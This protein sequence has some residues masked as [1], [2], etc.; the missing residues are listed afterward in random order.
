MSDY[1]APTAPPLP[2]DDAGMCSAAPV[3]PPPAD[4]VLVQLAAMGYPR[5]VCENALRCC[6]GAD[7]Q[8]AVAWLLENEDGTGSSIRGGRAVAQQQAWHAPPAACHADPYAASPN[9]YAPAADAS[10]HAAAPFDEELAFETALNDILLQMLDDA[11]VDKAAGKTENPLKET[12]V[13]APGAPEAGKKSV[14]AGFASKVTFQEVPGREDLWTTDERLHELYALRRGHASVKRYG[15]TD[16]VDTLMETVADSLHSNALINKMESEVKKRGYKV[17]GSLG[18]KLSKASNS[19]T[20]ATSKAGGLFSSSSSSA[21]PA[22]P[23]DA[24]DASSL[25]VAGGDGQSVIEV[26][27]CVIDWRSTTYPEIKEKDFGPTMRQW[28]FTNVPRGHLSG[29][30]MGAT[31]DAV[32]EARVRWDQAN[33]RDPVLFRFKTL[34]LR[35]RQAEHQVA[36]V[37]GVDPNDLK[38]CLNADQAISSVLKSL[39][40]APGDAIVHTTD[41]TASA[42]ACLRRLSTTHGVVLYDATA[43]LP[44]TTEQQHEHYRKFIADLAARGLI[45]AVKLA[46]FP[47]VG[48]R[49]GVKVSVRK[50]SAMF[51]KHKVSVLV[52][53]SMAVGNVEV[54]LSG[55]GADWYVASLCHWMFADA[56][57]GVI[58]A[59]P[60]KQPVTE[61]LTVSYFDRGL[62]NAQKHNLSFEKEFSYQGLQDFAGWCAVHQSMTFVTKICGGWPVVWRHNQALAKRVAGEVSAAWGTQPVQADGQYGSMPVVPLPNAAGPWCTEAHAAHLT[63]LLALEGTYVVHIVVLP[64]H[65]V[66]TLC[67]RFPCQIYNDA[68][69]YTEAAARIAALQPYNNMLPL[70][71]PVDLAMYRTLP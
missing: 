37:L 36:S 32:R 24:A 2:A 34:P 6:G 16:V 54:G 62:A 18:G 64:L 47:E 57:L 39:P 33:Q 10:A 26:M 66:N 53:G 61:T 48:Y 1:P 31:P 30:S 43:P 59:H 52:D 44:A 7:A 12:E 35:L 42:L 69:E 67:A 28:H 63:A 9:P 60:L 55:K 11:L 38:F 45:A 14:K 29:V 3:P 27:E 50:L 19:V 5:D 13:E 4:A 23:E 25:K 41:L 70:S 65:G 20:K 68:G 22:A 46:V 21:P 56:G 15:M 58:V 51:H 71:E 40:W 49:S 8:T 17:L